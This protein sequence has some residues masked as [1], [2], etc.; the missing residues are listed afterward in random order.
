MNLQE[1]R[2]RRLELAQ[3]ASGLRA[4]SERTAEENAQYDQ[5]IEQIREVDTDIERE[6][7]FLD[8]ER[9]DAEF[10][11][12]HG[13]G[14]QGG[15][16]SDPSPQRSAGGGSTATVVDGMELR[17]IRGRG[18]LLND[19]GIRESYDVPVYSNP[20]ARSWFRELRRE[21]P[22]SGQIGFESRAFQA[23]N[24]P[25]G[26]YLVRPEQFVARLIQAVD[27]AVFIRQ[28]A[29]VMQVT[30]ASSLGVPSLDTDA[31]DADWT[32]ELGTGNEEDTI[33]FGKR[34][35]T[36]HPLAKRVK[37]SREL[38]RLGV[39]D[40]EGI[41]L[42]RIAYKFGIT[43]EKAFLTGTGDRQPLGVY[44][45]SNDG[46]STGRDVSTGNTAT[47]MTF[48]GLQEAKF[49][50]KAQYWP[51]ARWNFHRDGVKQIS[52][53]KD[54]DGRYMWEPSVRAGQPDILFSFPV[55]VSEYTPSTFTTGQYVGM[56]ADFSHYWIADS[57]GMT[58]Q[59]LVELYAETNQ[60]GFI[61]RLQTDGM[62]V[63][64]EAFVRVKLA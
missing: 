45:A 30:E 55:D 48:D 26:G 14:G 27:N 25:E 5:T 34:A 32:V 21:T 36:P 49:T 23:D 3:R 22:P 20:A 50:L 41:V 17:T 39:L 61:A 13:G 4:K 18:V 2:A 46:I 57:M 47:A 10:M 24:D 40:P 6:E 64:E 43:Q 56:L 60:I 52:K 12:R 16:A 53:I 51:R 54:G 9:R 31:E 44:V 19:E 37:L 7:R 62:P 8:S 59:R 15:S 63:L 28:L 35:L 42:G 58:M 33:R 11:R 29:T 1:L 38:L